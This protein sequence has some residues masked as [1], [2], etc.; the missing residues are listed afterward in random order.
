MNPTLWMRPASRGVTLASASHI[1]AL[2]RSRAVGGRVAVD[3]LAIANGV[4]VD[5]RLSRGDRIK[6]VVW[7]LPP[8]DR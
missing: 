2:R 3:E 7:K 1:T 6:W 8:S 5:T 4:D